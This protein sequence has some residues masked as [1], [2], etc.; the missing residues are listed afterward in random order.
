[1]YST[2]FCTYAT[3]ELMKPEKAI[4]YYKGEV[5]DALLTRTSDYLR[6]RFPESSLISN[7][8]FAIFVELA[9]NIS[10]YSIERNLISE[11]EGEYG[12]GTVDIQ[13]KENHYLLRA[14]NI[15]TQESASVLAGRCKEINTLDTQGLKALRKE[16]RSRPRSPEQRGGNIGLIQVALRSGNPLEVKIEPIEGHPEYCTLTIAAKVSTQ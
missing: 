11:H 5:E 16:I 9:Q 3:I 10:R 14:R 12:V 15:A 2:C 4:I 13:K 8:L 1:M 6:A 7:R